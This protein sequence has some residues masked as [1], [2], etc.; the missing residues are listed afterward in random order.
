MVQLQFS[1]AAKTTLLTVPAAKWFVKDK[2]TPK[3]NEHSGWRDSVDLES[4]EEQSFVLFLNGADDK[5]LVCGSAS[6][7]IG[8]LDYGAWE[9]GIIATSDNAVG[10]EG[11]MGF[12]RTKHD[13]LIPKQPAFTKLRDVPPRLV[14][15]QQSPESTTC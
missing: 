6:T 2:T 5:V 7:P 4:S 13:G 10:F 14:P 3:G 9:V 1:N 12:T 15:V 8:Q 11:T